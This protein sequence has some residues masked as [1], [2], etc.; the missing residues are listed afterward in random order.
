M[1]Y[2]EELKPT[3]LY[4]PEPFI[5]PSLEARLTRSAYFAT[6]EPDTAA[7]LEGTASRAIF[8]QSRSTLISNVE[9]E[10]GRWYR[11]PS[12][13]ACGFCRLLATRGPVY[14]SAHAAAASH[15]R[16]KCKVA[17][18]RPGMSHTKPKYM[19]SWDD[20]YKRHRAEVI[21]EGLKPDLDN[22]VNAWNREIKAAERAAAAQSESLSR[23]VA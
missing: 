19:D 18:Q 6:G 22:I 7:F 14:K 11:I 5:D 9:R 15:D 17:V 2:Y 3:S 8:D 10:H 23:D 20:D 21:K 16:C 12:S 1:Q 13:T 4:L